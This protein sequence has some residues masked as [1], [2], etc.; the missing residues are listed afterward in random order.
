M[1]S[2]VTPQPIR[3]KNRVRLLG[4]KKN[5]VSRHVVGQKLASVSL[6]TAYLGFNE[7]LL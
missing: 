1:T 5:M 2:L 4:I 7:E 3:K 6:D